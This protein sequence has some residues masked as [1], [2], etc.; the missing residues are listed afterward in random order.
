MNKQ[1]DITSKEM[2]KDAENYAKELSENFTNKLILQSKMLAA[3][4]EM[5]LRSHVA[6]AY[7]IVTNKMKETWIPEMLK[8]IGGVCAGSSIAFT[9][10]A[11]SQN[12]GINLLVIYF[13]LT[14]LGLLV[15]ALALLIEARER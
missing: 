10:E 12:P 7:R 8:L 5:V 14:I 11:A 1:Q 9:Q 4:D 13:M 2:H 6:R 15:F 3:D